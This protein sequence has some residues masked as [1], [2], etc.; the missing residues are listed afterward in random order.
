MHFVTRDIIAKSKTLHGTHNAIGHMYSFTKSLI[1][2]SV[3]TP[4]A[5]SSNSEPQG[6]F[7]V[8]YNA[9]LMVVIMHVCLIP[10][11]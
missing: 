8:K 5:T 9:Y 10:I 7:H 6:A 11:V 4:P 3:K 1:D 2:Q